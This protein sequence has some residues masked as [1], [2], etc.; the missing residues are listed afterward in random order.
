ML[1]KRFS[2]FSLVIINFKLVLDFE[3]K[4]VNGQFKLVREPVGRGPRTTSCLSLACDAHVY[5][6]TGE[7]HKRA[8]CSFPTVCF[9]AQSHRTFACVFIECCSKIKTFKN[10]RT[11]NDNI[12]QGLRRYKMD[13]VIYGHSNGRYMVLISFEISTSSHR[14]VFVKKKKK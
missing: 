11:V 9:Y 5:S 1:G 8:L 14:V 6:T 2:T 7:I 13:I 4:K 12:I 3:K 10:I